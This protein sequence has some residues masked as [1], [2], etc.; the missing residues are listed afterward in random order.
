[1][2]VMAMNATPEMLGVY[3]ND[4][5]AGS[6][7]GLDLARRLVDAHRGTEL[8]PVL[9]RIANEV[10]EDR[11]VLLQLMATLGIPVRRYK[12]LGA[13]LVEKVGR[14]KLNG[15]LFHRSPLSGVLEL[16]AME[17]G[18]NGKAMG[19]RALRSV[20]AHDRRL[21]VARFEELLARAQTQAAVLEELR[22]R[23]V[24]DVLAAPTR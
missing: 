5:L 2:S 24:D 18:V 9:E 3:L 12:M 21:D 11:Q 23:A 7:A 16:E 6:R 13:W 1:M 10:V 4:H 8:S 22:V 15:R 14:L 19:W 20:A 17:L